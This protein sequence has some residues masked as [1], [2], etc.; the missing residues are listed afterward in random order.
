MPHKYVFPQTHSQVSSLKDM[1]QFVVSIQ[2]IQKLVKKH[3]MRKFEKTFI[4]LESD[5]MEPKIVPKCCQ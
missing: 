1:G 5:E 3:Q 2:F 4:A